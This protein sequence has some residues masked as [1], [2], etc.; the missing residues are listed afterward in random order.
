MRKLVFA[1]VI[2]LMILVGCDIDNAAESETSDI[3]LELVRPIFWEEFETSDVTVNLKVE[4]AQNID[5]LTVFIDGALL[6]TFYEEP[7]ETIMQVN[8]PGTHNIYVVATD[9]IGGT[10]SSGIVNFAIELPDVESPV[11]FITSPADWTTIT[12]IFDVRVSAVDN[13]GID[14]VEL[15]FDGL[16]VGEQTD[17]PYNFIIDSSLYTNEN[18]TI[19]AKITDT[20]QN[21]SL[22]QLVNIRIDN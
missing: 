4:S 3:S 1:A 6:H 21:F 18:H 7:Y 10:V 16:L 19:Y 11:G 17:N 2:I 15:F 9:V 22:T 20:S 8:E 12:G 5:S 14:K 13:V